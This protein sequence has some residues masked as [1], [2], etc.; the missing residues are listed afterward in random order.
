MQNGSVVDIDIMKDG[1]C[2]SLMELL[3]SEHTKIKELFFK[4][5]NQTFVDNK[6]NAKYE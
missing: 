4:L 2:D 6:L 1:S 3:D 5:L